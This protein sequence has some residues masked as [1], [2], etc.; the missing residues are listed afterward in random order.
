MKRPL[1]PMRAA[2]LFAASTVALVLVLA[3][4]ACGGGGGKQAGTATSAAAKASASA[5]SSAAATPTSTG[6]GQPAGTGDALPTPTPLLVT[7]AALGV[8]F[9]KDNFAPTMDAFN[10]L[11][12][13]SVTVDGKS[14]KGVTLATM[15]AKVSAPTD[16]GFVTVQ[17]TLPSG[18]RLNVIR[19]AT[20][21]VAATTV[22]VIDS[23][24][25]VALYSTSIPKDQWLIAVTS[26]AFT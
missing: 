1:L 11:D 24:G 5:A 8:A 6:L 2:T 10:A 20:K 23:G 25:R 26:V 17:G 14:Y 22:L 12:Q 16:S 3:V 13:T 9:G 4:A 18:T 19:F 7:D 21:D 15:A